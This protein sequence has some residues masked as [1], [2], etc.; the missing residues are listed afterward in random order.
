MTLD[1]L[2][3]VEFMEIMFEKEVIKSEEETGGGSLQTGEFFLV[4]DCLSF[5]IDQCYE[6]NLEVKRNST[7]QMAS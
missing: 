6:Y 5:S 7:D 3:T 1:V 4:I 2:D